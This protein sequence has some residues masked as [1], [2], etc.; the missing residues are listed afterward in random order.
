MHTKI[1]ILFVIISLTA[2]TFSYAGN[3]FTCPTDNGDNISAQEN[4][5]KLKLKINNDTFT[6]DESISDIKN[7]YFITTKK[8]REYRV[9]SFNISGV[10]YNLG[11]FK[12]TPTQ[13]EPDAK[14][15]TYDTNAKIP[16]Y[17]CSFGE[18]VNN[19]DSWK[20]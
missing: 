9:I 12:S 7:Q 6:S 1:N 14:L 15:F 16:D 8:D 5:G 3:L 4:N 19:F 18:E 2:S 17:I 20:Q 10:K 11:S 13:E